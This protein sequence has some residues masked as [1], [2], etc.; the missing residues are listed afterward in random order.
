MRYFLTVVLAANVSSS[1]L[2]LAADSAEHSIAE[3]Q[4]RA[5]AASCAVCHGTSGLSVG[6]TAS[7]AGRDASELLQLMLN[8]RRGEGSPTIMH[9]HSRGYSE[10][11]LA[12]LAE[13][14]S[15]LPR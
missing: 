4:V 9:Q 11:E 12:Q 3:R 5:W 2:V 15:H 14:F 8:F 1:S 7:L 6:G 10:A 13:Y